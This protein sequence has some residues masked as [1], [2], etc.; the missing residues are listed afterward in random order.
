M[1]IQ[2]Y[3]EA[4][5]PFYHLA[6]MENLDSILT[7]G[8]YMS[9]ISGRRH[10]ICVV[11]SMKDDIISEIIDR[12][13]Q[14]TGRERFALIELHPREKG[15]TAD[16]VSIDPIDEIISPMCNYI[17]IE[18]IHIEENDIVRQDISVGLWRS[19]TS[20]IVELTDYYCPVPPINE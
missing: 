11:R 13:L 10:G 4:N 5:L 3:I 2:E 6:K 15:I 14:E 12:Q 18:P 19:T 16:D 7:D 17:C 1:S 9:T 20:K 8:L